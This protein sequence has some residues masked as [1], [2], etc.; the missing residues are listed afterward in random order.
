MGKITLV[1]GGTKSGKTS[2][3][4]K[5]AGDLAEKQRKNVAYIATAR[6]LDEGMKARISAHA[7]SRPAEWETVEEPLE[8]SRILK[9]S[10]GD[11]AAVILDCLTML[12]TNIIMELR[13][14][15]RRED[16]RIMVMKEVESLLEAAEGI[17]P[18]LIIISN[19]VEVG[20]VAPTRLGG[21][22]QDIAGISHQAIA[23][24]ADEVVLMTAGIPLRIK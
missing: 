10:A 14:D 9:D 1:L 18:E 2:F 15:L 13:E 17:S 12:T 21:I 4:Q 11:K 19:Q 22:F 16:A 20:L 23:D 5:R 8:V 6:A 7:A 24:K 3:A